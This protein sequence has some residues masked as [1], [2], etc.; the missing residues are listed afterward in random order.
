MIANF[1]RN[2]ALT[3]SMVFLIGSV[4]W[5]P[6]SQDHNNTKELEINN[7][8][9]GLTQ[10]KKARLSQEWYFPHEAY[11]YAK[12]VEPE[13]GVPP[14]IDLS[15]SIEIPLFVDGKRSYG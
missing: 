14:K 8:F 13:L 9:S 12:M 1:K 3:G 4:N 6:K 2:Y 10:E 7:F 11:D 5:L 15:Q